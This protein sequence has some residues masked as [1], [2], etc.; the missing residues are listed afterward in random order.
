MSFIT[1]ESGI[2]LSV[3]GET[4]LLDC[5]VVINEGI[6][7]PIFTEAGKTI[8]YDGECL[9]DVSF[10]CESSRINVDS[11]SYVS[12]VNVCN[13]PITVTGFTN[14]N[15][16]RF[17][18]F[19][20]PAYRDYSE[21]NTGNCPHLPFTLQPYQRIV[22]D[23]F[24]H[25]LDSELTYGKPGTLENRNGDRFK[26]KIGILP[27]FEVINCRQ[28]NYTSILWWKNYDCGDGGEDLVIEDNGAQ[29]SGQWFEVSK[30]GDYT[31]R[32][33]ILYTDD[34][35]REFFEKIGAD[36]TLKENAELESNY[37]KPSFSLEGEFICPD[38]DREFLGNYEHFIEP[39]FSVI[40]KIQNQ[41]F[42]SKKPTIE[43]N[44][45]DNNSIENIFTG[46]SDISKAYASM[47][48]DKKW[49][50]TYGNLAISGSLAAFNHIV[51]KLI[52]NDQHQSVNNL[53]E[54]TL[55]PTEMTYE[56]NTFRFSYKGNNTGV[57]NDGG[58][59]WTG[60]IMETIPVSNIDYLAN[61]AIFFNA[62]FV[63]GEQEDVRMFIVDSGD[64]S[65]Y[66][67]EEIL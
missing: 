49:Y 20:Y 47:L 18:I 31:P 23:T 27:G 52:E 1:Q 22:I 12:I 33:E 5:G 66:P 8:I 4:Q 46:L 2:T 17:S 43:L 9:P 57:I 60:M 38:V 28:S 58:Y 61:Q 34:S 15:P 50:K 51:D 21:Y 39:D 6:D 54:Y 48:E 36:I 53:F 64:F 11:G 25:P 42:L 44:I 37:C 40:K 10:D 63:E 14:D 13:L 59:M 3:T 24:F 67:M 56:G 29:S 32:E 41:H 55:D 19:E 30:E 65:A 45:A 62:D 7:S 35:G 16:E 26:A